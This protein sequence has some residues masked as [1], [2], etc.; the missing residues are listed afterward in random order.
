MAVGTRYSPGPAAPEDNLGEVM[1]R[2]AR[3]LQEEHGDTEATLRAIT[4]AT[5]RTV[6][7]AEDCGITFVIGRRKLEPRAWTGELPR[8]VDRLQEELGQ[9]PCV[10]AVWDHEM[11]VV[12]DIR[13][14]ARW[15]DFAERAA[16]AGV[17]SMLCFQLFVEGGNLGALNVYSRRPGAFDEESQEIGHMVAAHAAIALAGAQHE[18]NLRGAMSHRDA[19]GQA[20]GILMERYK[21]TADQ[22][23]GLL[24]RTSSV[25][26]RKLRD[27]ADELTDTGRLPT[28]DG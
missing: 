6:P 2:V 23:F 13:T 18:T 7:N 26:N 8:T 3:H 24:V 17:G 12:D 14:D 19:I 22:A 15:P 27:V 1:S 25:L 10:D 9:G 21:I 20:K 16:D 28:R 5:V 11:V 4:T